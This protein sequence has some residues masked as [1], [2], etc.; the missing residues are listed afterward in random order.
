MKGQGFFHHPSDRGCE[1]ACRGSHADVGDAKMVD[2]GDDAYARAERDGPADQQAHSVETG[3]QLRCEAERNPLGDIVSEGDEQRWQGRGG[4]ARA[5]RAERLACAVPR[6][7]S[8]QQGIHGRGAGPPSGW[9]LH[10]KRRGNL[11]RRRRSRR[12]QNAYGPA[13]S[14]RSRTATGSR[15]AE[16]RDRRTPPAHSARERCPAAGRSWPPRRSARETSATMAE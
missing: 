15:R 6:S 8:N 4:Q 1:P 3:P 9:R 7:S 10:W 12:A 13:M 16:A 5:E 2:R 14:E 11:Q